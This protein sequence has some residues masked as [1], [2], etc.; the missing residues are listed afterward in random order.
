[1]N[2]FT[3]KIAQVVHPHRLSLSLMSPNYAHRSTSK[4]LAKLMDQ[5]KTGQHIDWI[6]TDTGQYRNL[7]TNATTSFLDTAYPTRLGQGFSPNSAESNYK[8][9][10]F[11]VP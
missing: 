5:T 2:V 8:K 6:K 1:M 10:V 3:K 7:A 4:G 9:T 11:L